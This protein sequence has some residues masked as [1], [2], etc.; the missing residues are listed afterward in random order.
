MGAGRLYYSVHIVPALPHFIGKYRRG[1]P[2]TILLVD[3]ADDGSR[4]QSSCR[5]PRYCKGSHGRPIT[6]IWKAMVGHQ[7]ETLGQR[8]QISVARHDVARDEK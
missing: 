2:A 1:Y 7:G 8:E 3:I 5:R 4:R 6:I